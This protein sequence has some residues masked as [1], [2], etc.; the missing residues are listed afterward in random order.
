MKDNED[1]LKLVTQ[2]QLGDQGSVDALAQLVQGKVYAYIY[3]LTLNE[4]IAQDLCQETLLT[5]VQSLQ[6][7]KQPD[8]FWPWLLR[9][10]LGKVQ[11]YFRDR[12][13]HLVQMS[14]LSE[15]Q[16]SQLS[17][18]NHNDGLN[19]VSRREMSE[20][21]IAAMKK[22]KLRYRNI[23]LL[24]CFEQMSYAEIAALTDSSELLTRVLFFR[25][26]RALQRLLARNGVH[27]GL[28]LT[29]LTLFGRITAPAEAASAPVAVTAATTKVGL[30]AAIIGAAGTTL[31]IATSAAV[32]TVA[33]TIAITPS[34]PGPDP[35]SL[36]AA[37]REAAFIR[38]ERTFQY[39]VALLGAHDGDN[40]G[41]QGVGP[42]RGSY[43]PV[44]PEQVLVG[45]PR[46]AV[47]S[48]TLPPDHWVELKFP[49]V[50]IDGPGPDIVLY[51]M[52]R[53]GEQAKVFLTDGAGSEHYLGLV[54]P[55]R[56]PRSG[57]ERI[58]FDIAGHSVPFTPCAVRIEGMDYGGHMPG[59]DLL[60]VR[61]RIAPGN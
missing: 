37:R 55:D 10:A 8:R 20:A 61:A 57:P 58:V 53:A 16:L 40:S 50:I 26:R 29:A 19:M 36:V 18:A 54:P 32:I 60:S 31:G 11:H 46:A 28:L 45:P 9:T 22:L 1:Y 27:K 12:P 17:T 35:N 30:T 21:V 33:A 47:Y 2:G 13:K 4:H 44:A 51:E 39:P 23:L 3:R 42:K 56:I 7:L 5:M 41:W 38:A 14:I 49:G 52:D 6:N 48:V 59:F 15:E 43:T 24:R 25:A 34:T